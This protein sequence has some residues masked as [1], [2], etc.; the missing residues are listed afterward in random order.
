MPLLKKT[1]EVFVFVLPSGL[2]LRLTDVPQEDIEFLRGV[3]DHSTVVKSLTE[4]A[5]ALREAL[6]TL[7]DEHEECSDADGWMAMLCSCEAI[8]VAEEALA[9]TPEASLAEVRRVERERV[10]RVVEMMAGHATSQV[11][12]TIRELE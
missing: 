5:G 9:S 3:T 4:Q 10:A 7:I 8:H 1:Y 6:K 11:L 12:K 2:E